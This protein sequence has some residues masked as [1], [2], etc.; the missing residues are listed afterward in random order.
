MPQSPRRKRKFKRFFYVSLFLITLIIGSFIYFFISNKAP[1]IY[2]DVVYQI[3]YNETQTLDLYHP[4]TKVYEKSPVVIFFHGGAWIV[5]R[6]ESINYNRFNKT[7]NQLRANGY[8]IISPSYTLA[9]ENSSPFPNCIHDAYDVLNWI[10]QNSSTYNFDIN[11][12][13]VFGESAGAHIA[14]MSAITNPRDFKSDA[15]SIPINYIVDVYGP[16]DLESLFEMQHNDSMNLLF[17]KVPDYLQSYVDFSDLI[18]GF[19]TKLNT[20]KSKLFME[21]YSPINYFKEGSPPML[22]IHGADDQ[23][24]PIQQSIL[25][26]SILDSLGNDFE[27]KVVKNADHA[28]IGAS[29]KQLIEVQDWITDYITKKYNSI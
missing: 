8:T 22:I 3:K 13:G 29:D 11:N 10:N 24:V 26:Q 9:N 12:V 5:G 14:M 4:T 1:I 28:F 15:L 16:T 2:G 18:I 7:I 21:K 6:K 27:F 19:D 25:L 20:D 23:V 17:S